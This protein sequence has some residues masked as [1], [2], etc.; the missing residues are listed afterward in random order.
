MLSYLLLFFS[1]STYAQAPLVNVDESPDFNQI[2]AL[3]LSYRTPIY[4]DINGDLKFS[5]NVND[6]FIFPTLTQFGVSATKFSFVPAKNGKPLEVFEH[7]PNDV[8]RILFKRRMIDVGVGIGMLHQSLKNVSN[9][10]LGIQPYVGGFFEARNMPET[11]L[12]K[13]EFWKIPL[14]QSLWA[15]WSKGESRTYQLYG[16]L[17]FYAGVGVSVLTLGQYQHTSQGQYKVLLEK[18][19]D[20][21]ALVKVRHE[22]LRKNS[23]LTGLSVINY[24]SDR[25]KFWDKEHQYIVDMN[26]E[27]EV[28]SLKHLWL[29][30]L[31]SLQLL[32][33]S[34]MIPWND[35]WIG[36]QKIFYYGIPWV[37][38]KTKTKSQ[39]TKVTRDPEQ[40]NLWILSNFE[41]NNGVLTPEKTKRFLL[42]YQQKM[43]LIQGVLSFE[44]D[45]IKNKMIDQEFLSWLRRLG[46][47]NLPALPTDHSLGYSLVT[48][49]FKLHDSE[50][51]QIVENAKDLSPLEYQQRCLEVAL[52]CRRLSHA[53]KIVRSIKKMR[54]WLL[55][56][57]E[58]VHLPRVEILRFLSKHPILWSKLAEKANQKMNVIFTYLGSNFYPVEKVYQIPGENV[59]P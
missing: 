40:G 20:S 5:L 43:G 29:G 3:G 16:G 8:G 45:R 31:R 52:N 57:T 36:K 50:L 59:R 13:G 30:D 26:N 41:M 33:E 56:E 22:K 12:K 11:K 6:K 48:L 19:S 15:K 37:A 44:K 21:K 1:L 4:I 7:A 49:S 23:L 39:L 32:K 18:V 10:A 34:R 17:T 58:N 55:S 28:Q 35:P 42:T 24:Q 38:G 9:L 54:Q 51:F 25:I 2:N 27:E 46:A 14:D 47:T 53:K